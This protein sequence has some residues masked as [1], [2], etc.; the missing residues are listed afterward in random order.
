MDRLSR[1]VGRGRCGF[2]RRKLAQK[3]RRRG[4]LHD[5][6][7]PGVVD[8][9]SSRGAGRDSGSVRAGSGR[10]HGGSAVQVQ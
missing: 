1:F 3:V 5:L 7:G 9:E 4:K 6:A 8:P 2:A 10:R